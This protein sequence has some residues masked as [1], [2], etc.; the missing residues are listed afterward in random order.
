[1][2]FKKKFVVSLILAII[3]GVVF[4]LVAGERELTRILAITGVAFVI[5]FT[6]SLIFFRKKKN[7]LTP[8]EIE[9]FRRIEQ[10]RRDVKQAFQAGKINKKQ[11]GEVDKGLRMQRG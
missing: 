10:Q 6:I 2:G 8:Q 7:K 11:F 5:L 4:Y 1:M 9:R 3:I